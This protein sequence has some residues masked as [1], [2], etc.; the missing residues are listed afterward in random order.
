MAHEA[1]DPNQIGAGT[2][3]LFRCGGKFVE[4]F[5]LDHSC[6]RSTHLQERAVT[7]KPRAKGTHPPEPAR[8]AM[9]RG[10]LEDV[11]DEG[12][13]DIAEIPQHFSTPTQVGF[14]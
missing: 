1:V 8:C 6:H 12:A 5:G 3:C 14:A 13:A 9:A 2:L 11:K 7:A 4:V 10:P